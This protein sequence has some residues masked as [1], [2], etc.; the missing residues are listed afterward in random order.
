MSKEQTYAVQ[1]LYEAAY[2]MA[3]GFSIVS[4]HT[5]GVK[6]SLLFE[7]TPKLQEEVLAFYNGNGRAS[8]KALFDSYRTAKDLAILR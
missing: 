7:S 1:N 4:K 3:R 8:A 6:T 2:L 5:N